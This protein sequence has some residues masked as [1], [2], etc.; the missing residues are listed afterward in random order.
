MQ[1]PK[2]KDNTT[3]LKFTF[4]GV[5]PPY[6]WI[7]WLAELAVSDTEI[8]LIEDVGDQ[9]RGNFPLNSKLA[10]LV[11]ENGL[12]VYSSRVPALPTSVLEGGCV[13]YLIRMGSVERFVELSQE[14]TANAINEE[15]DQI[16]E[17]ADMVEFDVPPWDE[18]LKK[19]EVFVDSATRRE[20]ERLIEAARIDD[21]GALDEV[22][23]ALVAAA[24]SGA[25]MNDLAEWGE[26][27][28]LGSKATF[29]RRKTFLEDD[30]VIYTESVP[31]E[32]GRPKLRLHLAEDL[33]GLN[34]DIG[35]EDDDLGISREVEPISDEIDR[36]PH[37]ASDSEKISNNVNSDILATIEEEISEAIRSK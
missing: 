13:H 17:S 19:L 34:I 18:L 3:G 30:G 21:L 8:V 16:L 7:E 15:F 20:F 4:S 31:V 6:E 37:A 9:L 11:E 2:F 28:G 5:V 10:A 24:Q 33:Q 26:C 35:I 29:S 36:D 22:S 14:E 25:L 23:V 32:I 1:L 12:S 27:V